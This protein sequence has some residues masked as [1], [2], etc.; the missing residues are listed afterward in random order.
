MRTAFLCVVSVACSSMMVA[1]MQGPP[2]SSTPPLRSLAKGLQSGIDSPR[3]VVARSRDELTAVWRENAQTAAMPAV[4]F[5]KEMVVGVFMGTRPTGGFATEI[6][7][8]RPAA[9]GGKDVVVEYRET[10][11]DRGA[12]AAQVIVAPFHLAVVPRQNGTV[13]FQ[14]VQR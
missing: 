12:I 8:Y 11:P 4:D 10:V 2:S 1:A 5:S 3:Q 7:G 9:P 14:K 13:T 6:V